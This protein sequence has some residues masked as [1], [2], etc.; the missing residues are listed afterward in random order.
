MSSR[1]KYVIIV[2]YRAPRTDESTADFLLGLDALASTSGLR[3]KLFQTQAYHG[4][5]RQEVLL[6][7][8]N[9]PAKV[10]CLFTND[11][12]AVSWVL[13]VHKDDVIPTLFDPVRLIKVPSPFTHFCLWIVD[14]VWLEPRREHLSGRVCF[15]PLQ[16]VKNLV[17]QEDVYTV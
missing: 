1:G 9:P 8:D 10:R 15:S 6:P 4:S 17:K 14:P 16:E 5:D 7:G 3:I 12:R 11:V 13:A 2:G